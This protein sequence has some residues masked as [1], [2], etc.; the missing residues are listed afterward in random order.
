MVSQRPRIIRMLP[1][2]VV[3]GLRNTGAQVPPLYDFEPSTHAVLDALLPRYVR[4]R[5]HEC[6]LEA[7][8]AET[9]SRQRAMKTAT[10]NASDLIDA[11]TRES[12]RARQASI[13]SELTE[14]VS[15]ADALARPR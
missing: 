14:I 15:S 10:D 5:I 8:A 11:L 3:Q 12:N 4:S 2:E 6:L 7:A 13:T 9:A 1:I